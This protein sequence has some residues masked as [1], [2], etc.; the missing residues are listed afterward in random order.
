MFERVA[1][2]PTIFM[3]VVALGLAIVFYLSLRRDE[4]ETKA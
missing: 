1:Y 4:R 2:D 3:L